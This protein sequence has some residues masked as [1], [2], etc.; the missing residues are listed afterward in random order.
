MLQRSLGGVP[1]ARSM[2]V[3]D[4]TD[5]K[6]LMI[7]LEGIHELRV[8]LIVSVATQ[9]GNGG[10]GITA[11]AWRPT[12]QAHQTEVVAEVSGSW[13]GSEYLPF[14]GRVFSLLYELDRAIGKAYGQKELSE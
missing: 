5:V 6:G 10:L 2:S 8:E 12:V 7:G 3:I 1:L 13:P 4:W 9:S 14:D 11:K